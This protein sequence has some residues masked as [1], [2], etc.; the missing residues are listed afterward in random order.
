MV[1]GTIE[2]SKFRFKGELKNGLVE[3]KGQLRF[4]NGE[5]EYQG[6]FREGLFEG[7]NCFYKCQE[8]SYKG[9]FRA[10][11]KEGYGVICEAESYG[12]GKANRQKKR[13]YRPPSKL[14]GVWRNDSLISELPLPTP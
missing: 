8:Y 1:S 12:Q 3:G 13:T 6:S 10:G 9:D 11:K 4:K 14:Y 7:E 5:A 2:S